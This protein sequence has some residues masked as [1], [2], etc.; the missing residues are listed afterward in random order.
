MRL[1]G[2]GTNSNSMGIPYFGNLFLSL[3]MSPR[4]LKNLVGACLDPIA[5]KGYRALPKAQTKSFEQP[6]GKSS[7]GKKYFEGEKFPNAGLLEIAKF[8]C[9]QALSL[10]CNLYIVIFKAKINVLELLYPTN[11]LRPKNSSQHLSP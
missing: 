8:D 7:H 2:E 9:N 3:R 11:K 5:V 1:K 6:R 10:S 4:N